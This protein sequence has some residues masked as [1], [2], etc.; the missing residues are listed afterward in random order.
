MLSGTAVGLSD[1]Y[2]A[3]SFPG[4]VENAVRVTI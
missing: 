2:A 4:S 1:A 3:S